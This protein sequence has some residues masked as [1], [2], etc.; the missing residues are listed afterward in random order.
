MTQTI[1]ITETIHNTCRSVLGIPDLQ[2]DEDFFER[3][4]S[5]LTIVELQIQIEQ[6]VQRQ[7][8]TSK[9]MAAPT[10]QG[11]SQVYREAAAS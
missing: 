6:L 1:D 5:S 10:V 7:V 11:W 9:L 2:S 8:P 3:G 4:V